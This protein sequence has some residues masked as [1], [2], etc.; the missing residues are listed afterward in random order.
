VR[1]ILDHWLGLLLLFSVAVCLL[2]CQQT[3]EVPREFKNWNS[4]DGA[5]ALEYP[6]AWSP[7]GG[8]DKELGSSW[9]KFEEGNVSIRVDAS[10]TQSVLRELMGTTRDTNKL[11]DESRFEARLH[12]YNLDFYKE[13]YRDYK[14]VNITTK[15]LPIGRARVAEFTATKGYGKLCGIRA[16]AVT[17]DKGVTFRALVPESQWE[18]FKPVFYRMLNSMERGVKAVH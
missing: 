11:P 7:Q 9:A 15:K 16:T 17:R 13:H 2:G 12:E 14:E 8:I 18:D 5:F 10:F 4:S 3:V 6:T 1:P